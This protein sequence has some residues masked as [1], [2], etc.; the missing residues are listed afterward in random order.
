MKYRQAVYQH[1]EVVNEPLLVEL[2]QPTRASPPIPSGLSGF[3]DIP[4]NISRVGKPKLPALSELSVVRHFVR[5]SQMSFGVDNGIYPLGSCTMKYNPKLDDVVAGLHGFSALHPDQ[6]ESSVQGALHVMWELQLFLLELTGMDAITLQPAAGSH[7]EFV[8]M[9]ITKA[10]FKEKGELS[11]RR[12]VLIPETAHGSNFASAA[13]AGFEVV[14][15]PMRD[16]EVDLDSLKTLCDDGV[17][18]FMATVPNTLG[19]FERRIL[20][21]SDMVHS[22]GALMYFDGANMNALIGVVKPAQLGFDI[23]HLNL[24]KTFSTPHGGGGP[25]SGPVAVKKHLADYLPIPRLKK[26]QD[27]SYVWDYTLLKSIGRIR[28]GFGNF[29]VLLRAY[30]YIRTLGLDGLRQA[31][32]D[33][34]LV[35]NYAAKKLSQVYSL[36]FSGKPRK[37][38]FVISS[39]PTGKRAF[40]IAKHILKRGYAP[41]IY[42]PQ[43][44]DEALMVEF[45][46]SETKSEVDEYIQGLIEAANTDLSSGPD[47]TAVGRLDEVR[48]AREPKLT[49]RDLGYG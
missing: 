38:E 32:R 8:G 45:T 9:L 49:W 19:L 35:S 6:D 18:A 36:P 34:V 17:A 27:G 11:K 3:V 44:V 7:G 30:T 33:S 39:K 31:A 46:E 20:E 41:T 23:A 12:K 42:F 1:S 25:G 26:N 48:A 4:A 24:H 22:C 16:G 13:M 2:H 15:V 28:E 43:L 47:N 37:H 21:I 10:Y 29:G 5:L 40:D 14:T